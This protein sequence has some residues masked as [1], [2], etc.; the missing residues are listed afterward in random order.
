[1]SRLQSQLLQPLKWSRT[2]PRSRIRL[3]RLPAAYAT[4]S[5]NAPLPTT[6]YEVFD[7]PSK[8]AQRDRAV[9]R[10]RDR[11]G[12][13]GAEGSLS[14]VDYIQ[15]ELAERIAD[16]IEVGSVF[17]HG[18]TAQATHNLDIDSDKGRKEFELIPC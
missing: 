3:P 16:R 15:E 1:M 17:A 8:T 11:A 5:P 9:L 10:L 14:V 2:L 18:V 7:E 6:P 12:P 4:I 13:S